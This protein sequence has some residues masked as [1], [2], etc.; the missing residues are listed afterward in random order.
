MELDQLSRDERIQELVDDARRAQRRERALLR[1][2]VTSPSGYSTKDIRRL[3]SETK[4]EF[5]RRG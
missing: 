5:L 3:C 4:E 1:A 2:P